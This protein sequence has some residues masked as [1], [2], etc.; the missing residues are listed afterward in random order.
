MY[1]LEIPYVAKYPERVGIRD[2]SEHAL[3]LDNAEK[4]RWK[5]FISVFVDS[6]IYI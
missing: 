4:A 1:M 6:I 3:I 5:T 2:A